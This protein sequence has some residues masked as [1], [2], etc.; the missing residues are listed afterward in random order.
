M[1][2]IHN[3]I[4]VTTID[5]LIEGVL[6]TIKS[7]LKNLKITLFKLQMM[8]KSNLKKERKMSFFGKNDSTETNIK[9]YLGRPITS[10]AL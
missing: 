5:E 2:P 1:L 10:I 8:K 6:K 3:K 7:M 4:F 9:S